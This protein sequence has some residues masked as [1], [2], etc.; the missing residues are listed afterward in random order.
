MVQGT[1]ATLSETFAKTSEN[2]D[3]KYK[4]VQTQLVVCAHCLCLRLRMWSLC[5]GESGVYALCAELGSWRGQA[6]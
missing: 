6:V 2:W 5:R 3:L 4:D 1:V